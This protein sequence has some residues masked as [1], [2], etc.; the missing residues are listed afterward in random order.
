MGSQ[1]SFLEEVT[2]KL[3][4]EGLEGIQAKEVVEGEG[5]SMK[6]KQHCAKVTK[7]LS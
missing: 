7:C 5:R 2:S 3:G 6:R 1:G 4:T